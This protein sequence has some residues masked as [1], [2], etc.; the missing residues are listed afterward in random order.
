MPEH[1]TE[2]SVHTIFSTWEIPE[3]I[4]YEHSRRWYLIASA[5][6]LACIIYALATQNYL[7]AVV[8]LLIAIIF[9]FHELRDP[10][11]VHFGITDKGIIFRGFLYPYKELRAFWII[12]DPGTSKNIYFEFNSLTMPRMAIP[13]EEQDPVEI[14]ATLRRFLKEDLSKEEEPLSELIGRVLKF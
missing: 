13:L 7:F 11:P 4:K 5:L 2:N 6:L 8:L 3:F 12:Y 14:R 10:T 9:I 1:L